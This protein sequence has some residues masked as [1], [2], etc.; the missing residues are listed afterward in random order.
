[1][2]K[3]KKNNIKNINIDTFTKIP[4]LL[5]LNDKNLFIYYHSIYNNYDLL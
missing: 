5:I 1:M 4:F 2:Y 3:Y